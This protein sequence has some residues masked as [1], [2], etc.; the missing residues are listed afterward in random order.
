MNPLL[1][2]LLGACFTFLL[3]VNPAFA[4]IGYFSGYIIKVH[5]SAELAKDAQTLEVLQDYAR[6]TM[7]YANEF[8]QA[9]Q[10]ANDA[11][12]VSQAVDIYTY[13][14][15]AVMSSSLKEAR[16]YIDRAASYARQASDESG[17]ASHDPEDRRNYTNLD[18]VSYRNYY[19]NNF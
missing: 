7:T 1:H 10:L 14:Q 4:E 12:F 15:R 2:S 9:A 8:Q 6:K 16:E 5:N 17:L 18:D 19:D 3:V 11:G 13:A